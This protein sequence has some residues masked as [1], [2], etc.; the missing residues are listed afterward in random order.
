MSERNGEEH[1]DA[2]RAYYDEFSTRYEARRDGHDPGGYHDLLDDLEVE[3][4]ERYG[5]R[6]GRARGRLRHRPAPRAH[7][8]ASR[9]GAR[10]STSRRHARPRAR[11][12]PRRREGSAT[13]LPFPDASFDVA[14][15]FKVLAH[16][17]DI[18]RAI[19]EM[20]RVVRPGGY[21]L[22]EL[23]NPREP[24]RP[25]QAPQAAAAVVSDTNDESAVFTRFDAP[26]EGR[27]S[28][29][30]RG[31]APRR[32]ARRSASSR[33]AA[34]AMR[35]PVLGSALRFAERA[36]CDSPLRH[37]GGFWVAV[38]KKDG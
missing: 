4:V 7:R 3:L 32:L 13:E 26:L 2:T 16:V 33:P 5:A 1:L 6:Q 31:D 12:R 25:R 34:V 20:A 15:S 38:L 17:R 9:G 10:A 18:D 30:P 14:C 24:A 8:A 29:G 23:Y 11:A 27:R 28:H 22:A 36:L 21:V 19:A 37:F 35:V